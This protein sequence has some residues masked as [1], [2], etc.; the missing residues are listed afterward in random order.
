MHMFDATRRPADFVRFYY[1]VANAQRQGPMSYAEVDE[2]Y[3]MSVTARNPIIMSL[4]DRAGHAAYPEGVDG[5]YIA[6]AIA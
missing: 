6:L 4:L 5:A 3:T 1:I 2:W